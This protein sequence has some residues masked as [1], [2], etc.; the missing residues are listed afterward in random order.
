MNSNAERL[1]VALDLAEEINAFYI[2]I[3]RKEFLVVKSINHIRRGLIAEEGILLQGVNIIGYF[4]VSPN[5]GKAFQILCRHGP[6]HVHE[7]GFYF[8]SLPLR[9]PHQQNSRLHDCL[10]FRFH[11]EPPP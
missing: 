11:Q 9:E 7:T 10:G 3:D 8:G 4:L 1:I 5:P 2:D 6:L